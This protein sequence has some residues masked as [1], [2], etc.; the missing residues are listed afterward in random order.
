M[1]NQEKLDFIVLELY[2]SSLKSLI[3]SDDILSLFEKI[4][5]QIS[6]QEIG[7]L[8]QNLANKGYIHSLDTKH[9]YVASITIEGTNYAK[10]LIQA[11]KKYNVYIDCNNGDFNL[12]DI[13]RKQLE[14]VVSVYK[15][16]LQ[17]FSINHQSYYF[18]SIDNIAI[19]ENEKGITLEKLDQARQNHTREAIY[20]PDKFDGQGLESFGKKVTGEFLEDEQFGYAKSIVS[21]I[22]SGTGGY[23]NNIRIKELESITTTQYDLSKLLKIC[24]ELNSNWSQHNYYT[25]GLLLRTIINHVPPLF[26]PT[27]SK[28]DQVASNYSGGDSFKKNMAHLNSSLRTIADSYNHELIR[29]KE[30]SPTETQ[31]DFRQNL[32][33]LLGELVRI[34]KVK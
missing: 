18:K 14:K 32:D 11:N 19:C 28:F 5:Y 27:F 29:E 4:K 26:N 24:N 3:S 2:Q 6:L 13:T 22:D 1:D 34:N 25:V 23:I 7:I 12:F 16:G 33:L 15:E 9:G 30:S 10:T 20:I 31:V 21:S 8:V 17:S